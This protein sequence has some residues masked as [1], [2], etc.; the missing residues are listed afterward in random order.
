MKFRQLYLYATLAVFLLTTVDA[1]EI[2]VKIIAFND[3]H[4]NLQSPGNFM[5]KESGGVEMLAGYVNVLRKKNENHVVVSVGDLIGASPL[6]SALFHD[7]GTIETMN[8]LGLDFSAVGNH[9]FDE[10]TD[11]LLR[12]QYGGCHPI[13]SNSCKGALVGTPVPFERAAFKY[14]AAN[15]VNSNTG[16]TLLP[17]YGV[18]AFGAVSV[19]FIG[20]TLKETPTI[21]MPTAV[22]GVRF[23]DEADAVNRVIPKLRAQGIEAIIVLVHQGGI[24]GLRA[25]NNINDC[26][27]E[28]G[29]INI[30]P[31]KSIVS[32][33]DDEVD[34]VVSGHTHV[35]YNCRLPNRTGRRIPVTQAGAYGRVLTDIDMSIDSKS[36]D[37]IGVV[38]N[39]VIVDRANANI[40]PNGTV[41][42]I[43]NGYNSLVSSVANQVIGSI[44]G[45]IYSLMNAHGEMDLGDL[46]A[47][48]QLKATESPQSGGAQI[49]FTNPGGVRGRGFAGTAY[50]HDV[51]YNDA[52]TVQP[53]GDSLVTMTLTAQQIKDVL[54]QQFA[55]CGGQMAQRI[56]QV[57]NGFKFSWSSSQGACSKIIDV[58]LNGET[59]VKAGQ[60]LSPSDTYRV[61][62]NSYLSAG[63]DGFTAFTSGT[64]PLGAAQDM[65]ALV[66]YMRS[67]YIFPNAPYNPNSLSLNKPRI[68]KLQ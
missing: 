5:G 48:A 28:L 50:P 36:G 54:E 15:V 34:L 42:G 1:A 59:I 47:D 30:S 18:K 23:L 16:H 52:F 46:I 44:A 67:H 21:V 12:M 31:I 22:R 49:A 29:P 55:G 9:E 32:Q 64:D 7:E 6:I 19:G 43:V 33:L 37:V 56:L 65:D 13:D 4:G 40:S 24:Q 39:N 68:T 53:F 20:I 2:P 38:V 17:P 27:R 25:P 51:T 10:G 66:A 63:G 35:A 41:Q 58:T 14:L 57:S 11:E 26:S 45:P 61:T 8:R 3:F 62:V 60:V